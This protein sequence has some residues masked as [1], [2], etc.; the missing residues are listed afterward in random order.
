MSTIFWVFSKASN[1]LCHFHIVKNV[2][3]HVKKE[4][5]LW[6]DEE[7]K[8]AIGYWHNIVNI[9]TVNEYF[10]RWTDM[11]FKYAANPNLLIYIQNTWLPYDYW[12]IAVYIHAHQHMSNITTNWLKEGHSSLKASLRSSTGDLNQ[13]VN[14]IKM[15]ILN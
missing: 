11:Q 9:K 7:V 8:K 5:N 6:T 12:F 15:K 4:I 14:A 3:A 10:E 1:L 13:I 2:M